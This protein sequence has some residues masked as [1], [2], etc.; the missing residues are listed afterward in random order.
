MRLMPGYVFV[1]SD[2]ARASYGCG[3]AICGAEMFVAVVGSEYAHGD[4]L[5]LFLIVFFNYR[6]FFAL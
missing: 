1:F 5:L 3:F 6:Q 4:S 2:E